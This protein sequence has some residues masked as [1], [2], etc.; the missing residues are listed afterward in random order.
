MLVR[1][2]RHWSASC[3]SWRSA[4]A[5]RK[6]MELAP[7]LA[8]GR[9]SKVEPRLAS[10]M[11]WEVASRLTRTAPPAL[12]IPAWASPRQQCRQSSPSP[13]QSAPRQALGRH[14]RRRDP[15][16][17]HLV[18]TAESAF[19]G[20]G[21]GLSPCTRSRLS[22]P[23]TSPGTR[24]RSRSARDPSRRL[25]VSRSEPRTLRKPEAMLVPRTPFGE[26]SACCQR[27]SERKIAWIRVQDVC[28]APGPV[29]KK[30]QREHAGRQDV[31]QTLDVADLANV[32]SAELKL[33][34]AERVQRLLQQIEEERADVVGCGFKSG[35]RP[36]D[37]A[38]PRIRP[39]AIAPLGEPRVR[40]T[41]HSTPPALCPTRPALRL[42]AE[43]VCDASLDTGCERAPIGRRNG[44]AE[45]LGAMIGPP[46]GFR[47]AGGALR[48]GGEHVQRLHECAAHVVDLVLG[49]QRAR[50]RFRPRR[51][52]S[53]ATGSAPDAP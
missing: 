32:L 30:R 14:R 25:S 36:L 29:E 34:V 10:G 1:S 38:T 49:E 18:I 28:F 33:E 9:C 4:R 15:R 37:D 5:C 20:S 42:L 21:Q 26:P 16:T 24:A 53:S 45:S 6:P 44:F 47:R 19:T 23:P 27:S 3:R 52:R 43:D 7:A 46:L 48:P 13:V 2:G 51:A 39:W 40:G 35:S 50:R 8:E 41:E 31:Q 11:T 17:L 22:T 12:L